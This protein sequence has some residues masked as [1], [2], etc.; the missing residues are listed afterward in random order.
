MNRI[1]FI[2][3]LLLIGTNGYGQASVKELDKLVSETDKSL[4]GYDPNLVVVR[5]FD[6]DNPP[7]RL[8]PPSR[9]LFY[10]YGITAYYRT[11]DSIAFFKIIRADIV[12]KDSAG[13]EIRRFEQHGNRLSDE[14]KQY[15]VNK[16]SPEERKYIYIENI[17]L[18]D[19]NG[20]YLKVADR[21]FC[22]HCQ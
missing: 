22:T 19:K 10:G 21:V 6:G 2:L 11:A 3:L 15:F 9:P 5:S 14:F 20:R 7:P 17:Y 13:N 16:L 4:L 8:R 1:V 18:Q 12:H